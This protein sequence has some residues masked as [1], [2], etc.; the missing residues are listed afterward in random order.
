MARSSQGDQQFDLFGDVSVDDPAGATPADP[1]AAT[2]RS[3]GA[4]RGR[5]AAS[6]IGPA[7]FAPALVELGAALPAGLHLGTSSWSFPGWA[8][9]VY[10][11]SADASRLSREGLIAYARHPLLRTVGIDRTFYAPLSAAAFARHAAQVPAAFRFLVKAPAQCTSVVLRTDG[12]PAQMND[13]FL[14]EELAWQQFVEPALAGLGEKA[15]PLVFQFSPL[16]RAWTRVPQRF[17]DALHPFLAALRAR[18]PAALLAVE[19]RDPE[20][21]TD[22]LFAALNDTGVRYCVGVHARMPAVADQIA[23]AGLPGTGPMVVRWNLHSGFG[24]DEAKARYEPFDRL[25]DED[26]VARTALAQAAVASLAAGQP[27]YVIANNKAEGSA[28][29]TLTRLAEAVR[30]RIRGEP[31]PG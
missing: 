28:P 3:P 9:L 21:L 12:G 29:L 19:V 1:A 30:A 31:P 24:Y 23:R 25:V 13:S 16:G 14:D 17:A 11:R 4:L 15:G 8:G 5:A 2:G 18:A 7:P 10:D 26:P 27:V 6:A 22:A 20:V